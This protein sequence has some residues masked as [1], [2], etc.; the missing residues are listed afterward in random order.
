MA[1]IAYEE[2]AE[3]LSPEAMSAFR[4]MVAT[5]LAATGDRIFFRMDY[6]G[7]RGATLVF[8]SDSAQRNL[9]GL[10]GGALE[11][12][13]SYGLLH[14]S[15][16]G[17]KSTPTYRVGSEAIAFYRWVMLNEG[18]GVAQVEDEVQL[19]I[20]SESFA[21][22]HAGGAH[23]LREAFNLLWSGRTDDQVASEIG[24]HLR[25][26]L[27]DVTIDVVGPT[28][29]RERPVKALTERL[30]TTELTAREQ[31]VLIQVVELVRVTLRLDHRLNHIRDEADLGEPEV[32]WEEVRRACFVTALAC[33][34]LDRVR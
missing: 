2:L 27:M 34:E 26:A 33:Y 14:L 22:S 23:H 12:L 18:S 29:D 11:D 28:G 24:D 5:H 31:E 17:R 6:L 3:R 15:Y 9:E 10:D 20:A 13:V 19:V 7:R 4:E 32:R 30:K 21:Q 25:K 16:T 8:R 1:G